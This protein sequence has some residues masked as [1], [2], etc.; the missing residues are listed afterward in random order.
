MIKH[1]EKNSEDDAVSELFSGEEDEGQDSFRLT[2]KCRSKH[3][4]TGR[5]FMC[6]Y[7]D[8]TYLS[9]PALYT[10]MK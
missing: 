10:H 4:C 7:C 9:Y 2:G 3:D 1:N 6:K 8:K 5:N